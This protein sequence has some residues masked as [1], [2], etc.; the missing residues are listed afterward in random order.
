MSFVQV[1][2]AMGLD[3]CCF[4]IAGP[5]AALGDMMACTVKLSWLQDLKTWA[6]VIILKPWSCD[7][8]RV[9]TVMCHD[10]PLLPNQSLWLSRYF[11]GKNFIAQSCTSSTEDSSSASRTSRRASSWFALRKRCAFQARILFFAWSKTNRSSCVVSSETLWV[12]IYWLLLLFPVIQSS[13]PRSDHRYPGGC[14]HRNLTD[15]RYQEDHLGRIAYSGL[16]RWRSWP[17]VPESSSYN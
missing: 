2:L 1:S 10:R 12:G 8:R 6:N 16:A 9:A 4:S 13:A 7:W 3:C 5:Y 17:H 14:G 15:S 11:L